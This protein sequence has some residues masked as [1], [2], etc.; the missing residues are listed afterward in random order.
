M[1]F[2]KGISA[3][4]SREISTC[5]ALSTERQDGEDRLVLAGQMPV[6]TWE[7]TGMDPV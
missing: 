3:L 6:C 1:G 4:G 7:T 5:T 2:K